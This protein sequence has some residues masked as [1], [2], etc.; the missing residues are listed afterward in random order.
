MMDFNFYGTV[1][2][3]NVFKSEDYLRI[4]PGFNGVAF[5]ITTNC[6]TAVHF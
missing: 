4:E 6:T 5:R 2:F 1:G 3:V